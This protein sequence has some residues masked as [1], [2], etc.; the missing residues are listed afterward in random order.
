MLC[1]NFSQ[2]EVKEFLYWCF[3]STCSEK[4]WQYFSNLRHRNSSNSLIASRFMPSMSEVRVCMNWIYPGSLLYSALKLR[5]IKVLRCS[6]MLSYVISSSRKMRYFCRRYARNFAY[7]FSAFWS[8]WPHAVRGT[9]EV[10]IE[11]RVLNSMEIVLSRCLGFSHCA[12]KI[13]R[14]YCKPL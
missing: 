7:K 9:D 6:I 12:C 3:A 13:L 4:L 1:D 11:R 14:L 10:K 5:I 2:I 8:P